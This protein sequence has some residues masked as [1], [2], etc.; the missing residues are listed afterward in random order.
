MAAPSH[1]KTWQ[2]INNVDHDKRTDFPVI[3][4]EELYINVKNT[5]KAF[6]IS[7]W[8]VDHSCDSITAGTP[9]DGVDRWISVTDLV[10]ATSGV[11]SWIVLT[12]PGMDGLQICIDFNTDNSFDSWSIIIS[13][14]GD[15]S[16]G[17]T[18]ARPTSSDDVV[19]VDKDDSGLSVKET[20][21]YGMM[22][23]DGSCTRLFFSASQ[24]IAGY[25]FIETVKDPVDGWV[26]PYVVFADGESTPVGAMNYT[27]IKGNTSLNGSANFSGGASENTISM[28]MEGYRNRALGENAS[29]TTYSVSQNEFSN[30]FDMFPVGIFCHVKPSRGR[31]GELF[32]MYSVSDATGDGELFPIDDDTQQWIVLNSLCLPWNDDVV[33][34]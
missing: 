8:I 16:G 12:Q 32:D 9:G 3:F 1:I 6:P 17:T 13:A 2:H 18:S 23:S 20:Y 33:R 14:T 22:S 7:P 24:V 4:Q 29:G 21:V 34:L 30:A 27:L 15:F 10:E 26:D 25:L 5:M 31:H 28:S 19:C 11:H